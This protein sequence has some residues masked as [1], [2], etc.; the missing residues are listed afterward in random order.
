MEGAQEF[1]KSMNDINNQL[2]TSQAE[3]SKV[4]NGFA[5]NEQNATTLAA[6]QKH[7]QEAFKLNGEAIALTR[8][9]LD[10]ATA[11]FG[12]NSSEAIALR[13]E[14][15]FLE[16]EQANLQRAL[17]ETNRAIAGQRW[18][19]L[20]EKMQATGQRMQAVG[21][22]MQSVGKGL[23]VAVT[24]PLVAM[25]AA[26]LVVGEDFENSMNKIQS[27]T[28]MTGP[29]I[30]ELSAE[31]RGLGKSQE[32]GAFSAREIANAYSEVATAGDTVAHATG[33]MRYSMV[34]ATA[35]N[36]DLTAA[37]GFLNLALVK[38]QSDIQSAERY[39]NAFS[40]VA[41]E[42]GMK[43]NVLEKAI[44]ALAPTMN[45]TGASIEKMSGKL[46]VLYRGGIYG[47]NAARG[48]EQMTNS[49]IA[50][51]AEWEKLGAKVF[52]AQGNM[53][54]LNDILHD[55]M[56]VLDNVATEQE[57]YNLQ[58][59]MF[60]T[61]Y[62]RAVFT[63]LQNNR[64]AWADS[65]DIMYEAT[66]AVDG[67]GRAFEMAAIR[68]ETL[69]NSTQQVRA[70]LEEIKLQIADALMPHI[71][72]L[73]DGIGRVVERFASLDEGTQRTIIT[74]AGVAAAVGPVLLV[75][76]KLVS[77]AGK[78]TTG[79]GKMVSAIGA[80]GGASSA[81]KAKLPLKTK[82]LAA[83]AVGVQNY[84]FKMALLS[85]RLTNYTTKLTA[86]KVK[87]NASA[88]TFAKKGGVLKLTKAGYDALTASIIKTG[89]AMKTKSV[90]GFVLVG[91]KLKALK[92]GLATATGKIKGFAAANTLKGGALK[93]ASG[94]FALLKKGLLAA[95]A[96]V[97]KLTAAMLA[98]P[99]GAIIA[100]VAALA[101]GIVLLVR[102]ITR[103]TETTRELAA[104]SEELA[105]RQER[106]I[107][108][109]EAGAQAFADSKHELQ[110]NAQLSRTLASEVLNL[111]AAQDRTA[112]DTQRLRSGIEQLNDIVPGLGLAFNEYTGELNMSTDA[113]WENLEAA[114]AQA[115]IAVL[116]EERARL[117]REAV[118]AETELVAVGRLREEIEQ[119]IADGMY[120]SNRERAQWQGLVREL[121]EQEA[122]LEGQLQLTNAQIEIT[123]EKL[124]AAAESAEAMA[125]ANEYL[126]ETLYRTT[127]E[128]AAYEAVLWG[129][130][131]SQEEAVNMMTG[132][133]E[134]Y[135]AKTTDLFNRIRN[136]VQIT[137]A[138][139][140]ET[141]KHNTRVTE[142]WSIN[143]AI[144][145]ERAIDQG[146]LDQL[147][148][149]TPEAM[150]LAA[151][152]VHGCA[153]EVAVLEHYFQRGLEAANNA[154]IRELARPDVPNATQDMV[155]EIERVILT[156]NSMED[157]LTT[158]V[159]N[160]HGAGEAAIK[161]ANFPHLGQGAVD[162]FVDG[163]E[164]SNANAEAAGT[165]TANAY[166]DGYT[167]TM[168]QN[169][170][171]Q[172]MKRKGGGAVDG[173][174]GGV[175]AEIPAAATAGSDMAEAYI[176]DAAN[177]ILADTSI[178][179]NARQAI[180]RMRD[181][182]INAVQS[183]NFPQ[184]GTQAAQGV[185]NG[186]RN[187]DGI[188]SAAAR[189]IINNAL[190]AMRAAAAIRS[191]S[192]ETTKIA[193]MMGAGIVRG[194]N[195]YTP[196]AV[197]AANNQAQSYLRAVSSTLDNDTTV[198]NSYRTQLQRMLSHAGEMQSQSSNFQRI[199]QGLS[200]DL[201]DGLHKGQVVDKSMVRQ[202]QQMKQSLATLKA[203][204]AQF[205]RV[206]NELARKLASGTDQGT[207]T[208]V[209]TALQNLNNAFQQIL[210][211]IRA[212]EGQF[213]GVGRNITNGVANGIRSGDSIVSAAARQIINN[214]LSAM[215][216]AAQIRSPARKTFKIAC[217]LMDGML[218]GL[219]SKMG[220]LAAYC[221]RI[222]DKVA[223]G[224]KI[225]TSGIIENS[226]AVLRSMQTALPA[227]DSNIKYTAHPLPAG[228]A[229]T[230]PPP[231]QVHITF[232]DVHVREDKD[233]D[234]IVNTIIRKLGKEVDYNSKIG[235]LRIQ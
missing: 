181:A 118:Q 6:K 113:L 128:M 127:A 121:T 233:I 63:E 54:P 188:V 81:L 174:V 82:A 79:F 218:R 109:A 135:A 122:G 119:K 169:S 62:S 48:I 219:D 14:L 12:E 97:I 104:A 225:D 1:K 33:L 31:F 7:L 74:L 129:I 183:L 120:S 99:I 224:L 163:V 186:I 146:I 4:T 221:K 194:T 35:T 40:A 192:H 207:N 190:S 87:T 148:T 57:R 210:N 205:Q 157:A 16:A 177:A 55:T 66:A 39:I 102:H 76:G 149:G 171:S 130:A 98:N 176:R 96:G 204:S 151:A 193:E 75:G 150:A 227:L 140:I 13:R 103:Q 10:E 155:D 90:D 213:H 170:P 36:S 208:S 46:N 222:T 166:L 234:Q 95:T 131:G 52:D 69:R 212:M 45:M 72:R 160:A 78:I 64:Q 138:D 9:K 217:Q 201:A 11:Q 143:M 215:R 83:A 124:D 229:P 214:A 167:S 198:P 126:I 123:D 34:L 161:A 132:S 20:G 84:T 220:E 173:F 162:G 53:R 189:Q 114:Q 88:A 8:N 19:E 191:P 92:K 60:T 3:L 41:G 231:A 47:I 44:V 209:R 203:Q 89:K 200:K 77:T 5:K 28:R 216:A 136:D 26:A 202:L 17:D 185:A 25:G 230:P 182:S 152:M 30:A 110:E 86:V 67:T 165:G 112:G 154:A 175:E 206:G 107:E 101:A 29:Q 24:A 105:D 65:V 211:Q 2:K 15:A 18:T 116:I 178:P 232:G 111:A 108:S 61:V 159:H 68:Q 80:A 228:H 139:V 199:G 91:K 50:N 49:L 184:V 100:G 134:S 195:N 145:A 223:D 197:A 141:L 32:Y 168:E 38:T 147:A 153:D 158:M 106:L 43:I 142:E 187:G 144:L 70:S 71:Q 226:K 133:F 125:A 93:I 156:S 164:G 58:N 56:T 51:A 85:E 42:S 235:G 37:T 59:R 23:S 172:V 137:I 94:G 22:K 179:E 21:D 117:T 115:E 180:Q 73:T 196:K 27:R